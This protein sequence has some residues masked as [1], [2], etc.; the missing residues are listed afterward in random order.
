MTM[1]KAFQMAGMSRGL[2]SESKISPQPSPWLA[3][4]KVQAGSAFREHNWQ[5][6]LSDSGYR[7]F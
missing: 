2:Q 3:E 1:Q 7:P 5:A 4:D 6:D